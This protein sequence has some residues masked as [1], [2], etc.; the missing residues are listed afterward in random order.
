MN[1]SRSE[2]VSIMLMNIEMINNNFI[3]TPNSKVDLCSEL[4]TIFNIRRKLGVKIII[5]LK[6]I[7]K[8][9]H[10]SGVLLHRPGGGTLKVNYYV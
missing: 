1:H 3:Y 7:N 8:I 5:Q 6:Y 9:I 2:L 10:I 4:F